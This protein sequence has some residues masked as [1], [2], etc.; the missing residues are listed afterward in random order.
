MDAAHHVH[1]VLSDAHGFHDHRV[2]PGGVQQIDGVL[3]GPRQSAQGPARGHAADEDPRVRRDAAH[4]DAVPQDGAAA[5]GRGGVH[6]QDPDLLTPFQQRPGDLVG[7]RGFP[8]SR[9]PGEAQNRGFA[10]MGRDLGHERPG[11]GVAIL[12]PTD[13]PGQGPRIAFQEWPQQLAGVVHLPRM[14]AGAL[15]CVSIFALDRIRMKC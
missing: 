6:R 15:E 4:A 3:G 11:L 8:R 2:E 5:E 10:K 14:P 12:H 9:C 7:Q 1:L 13:G